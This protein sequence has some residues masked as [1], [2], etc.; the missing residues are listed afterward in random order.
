M[1][2]TRT[3][4]KAEFIPIDEDSLE[5]ITFS[6]AD[7]Y[8]TVLQQAGRLARL[9][10]CVDVYKINKPKVNIY[11]Y[12]SRGPKV[13]L[14]CIWMVGKRHIVLQNGSLIPIRAITTLE[15]VLEKGEG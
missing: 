10:Q 6:I 2:K 1:V 12:D 13:V 14:S 9:H 7:V 4:S 5:L 8:S 3:Y 11:F 15:V